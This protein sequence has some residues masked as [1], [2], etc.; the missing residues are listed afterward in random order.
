MNRLKKIVILICT[1]ALGLCLCAADRNPKLDKLTTEYDRRISQLAS[2]F[3]HSIDK[4]T[5]RF[6]SD[7]DVA[8]KIA[9][10]DGDLKKANELA[11]FKSKKTILGA[12]A[13]LYDQVVLQCHYTLKYDG[14][15][16]TKGFSREISLMP[17]GQLVDINTYIRDISPIGPYSRRLTESSCCW[18]IS[19]ICKNRS[20][21]SAMFPRRESSRI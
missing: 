19:L 9:M 21:C 16:P 11:D 8:I 20:H 1:P 7:V 5:H 3:Q 6:D 2:D 18:C 4:E 10:K 13:K 14:T 15:G 17:F 12:A